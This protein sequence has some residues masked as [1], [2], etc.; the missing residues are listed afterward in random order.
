[1]PYIW[2][3][4][5]EQTRGKG[6]WLGLAMIMLTSI[7]LIAEARS[8]PSDLGFEALL[9]SMYDMNIY[10]LPLFAI[11]LASFSIFQEKELKT[12]M[13]LLTKK[14][15]I[16]TFIVKKSAAIQLVMIITFIGANFILAL[17]MKAFLNFHLSS[18]LHFILV[19]IVFLL[20][21]NQIGIFLGSICKTKMQ[22]V[23]A[24]ILIWFSVV[25]L[26]DLAFLYALPAAS[27][28]NL[29]IFSWV[30]FL[31]PIHAMRFYLETELGLF[32]LTHMSRMMDKF[33]L[34]EPWIFL[35][36]NAI[37]WPLLFF[38]LTVIIKNGGERHD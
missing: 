7:F 34:M 2:K 30:Y 31:N 12:S 26:I 11:F 27:F 1:M 14:E 21:F 37:V 10:L 13:I 18:F 9:L 24:N 22:L 3:E 4:A 15:S 28:D 17:F 5:L 29:H 32:G 6:L 23:G 25:F 19:I 20:I 8:F 16:I 38:T 33:I 35:M 36:I